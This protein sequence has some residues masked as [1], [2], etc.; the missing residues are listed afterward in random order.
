M[1][2]IPLL[3]SLWNYLDD[4]IFDGVGLAGFKRWVNTFYWLMLLYPVLSSTIVPFLFFLSIDW[5]C[6]VGVIGLIWCGSLSSSLAPPTSF[7]NNNNNI[8][9]IILYVTNFLEMQYFFAFYI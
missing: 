7:N 3:V 1:T 4:P 5:Y 2:F 8:I 9:I 6:G